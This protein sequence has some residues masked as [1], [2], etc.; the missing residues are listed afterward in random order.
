[1]DADRAPQLKAVVIPRPLFENR[2]NSARV[3]RL[4]SARRGAGLVHLHLN[5]LKSAALP[6]S[7][8][9]KENPLQCGAV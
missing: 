1:L 6:R 5:D 3:E 9:G 2:K 8:M 4:V 7:G